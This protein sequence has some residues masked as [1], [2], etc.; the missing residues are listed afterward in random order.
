[1]T[2]HNCP[3]CKGKVSAKARDH[4]YKEIGKLAMNSDYK[5]QIYNSKAEHDE[6]HEKIIGEIDDE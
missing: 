4:V 3:I 5:M 1:M 2:E 6:E